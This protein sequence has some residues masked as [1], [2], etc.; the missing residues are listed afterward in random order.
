MNRGPWE[1]YQQPAEPEP[2]AQGP[3]SQYTEPEQGGSFADDLAY[4]VGAGANRGIAKVLGA[5]VDLVTGALNLIPGVD[6]QDPAGGS[7]QLERGMAE[8]GFTPPP[9]EDLPHPFVGRVAEEVG[10]AAVPFGVVGA[11]ARTAATGGHFGAPLLEAFRRTPRLNAAAESAAA[12]GAGTGAAI[13]QEVAPGNDMAELAGQLIG[14]FASP[15]A[16]ATD[17]TRKIGES[18][19]LVRSVDLM[20]PGGAR[21][22]AVRQLQEKVG[23]PEAAARI[24][25]QPVEGV[26][27][28]RLSPAQETGD[29][30]LLELERGLRRDYRDVDLPLQSA[31]QATQQAIRDEFADLTGGEARGQAREFLDE[32]LQGIQAQMQARTQQALTRAQERAEA[33][34]P[35]TSRAQLSRITRE[36]IED[37]LFDMR[38]AERE[39][40]TV[41]P[42]NVQADLTPLKARYRELLASLPQAQKDDMP[43]IAG[44][45]L[46]KGEGALGDV[47]AIKQVQGLRSKLLEVARNARAGDTPN[48]NQ[49][50][51]ADE[52]QEAALDVMSR[53]DAGPAVQEALAWSRDLN[54]RFRQGAVG[55]VLGQERRGGSAVPAEQT[56][57]RMVRQGVEGGVNYDALVR[58]VDTPE[59]RGAV[60]DYMR[61]LFVH[62]ATDPKGR[63]NPAAAH[64]F[65]RQH[66]EVLERM[67]EIRRQLVQAKSAQELAT[68]TENQTFARQ[69]GLM[70]K[71]KSRAALYLDA[72][73]GREM[74]AVLNSRNPVADMRQLVRQVRHDKTGEALKGLRAQFLDEALDAATRSGQLSSRDLDAFLLRHQK[75]L[76]DPIGLFSPSELRR[77]RTIQNTL[78]KG[79]NTGSA[80]QLPEL[81]DEGVNSHLDYVLRV[82][83]A[84]VG[85]QVGIGSAS[86]VA[87]HRGSALARAIGNVNPL[88]RVR[89]IL[90]E[91]VLDREVMADLLR[92]A[93]TRKRP[94]AVSARMNAWLA[95]LLPPPED[96]VADE[97]DR[98]PPWITPTQDSTAREQAAAALKTDGMPYP[99]RKS[100][101][102]AAKSRRLQGYRAVRV[103]GG[104]G[105]APPGG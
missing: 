53:S 2:A 13:A 8:L 98:L 87:A 45:L 63:V 65:L 37:A 26:P 41:V 62:S 24:L 70:D 57:D 7:R 18:G 97:G 35:G 40:W 61:T 39:L 100:A 11:I 83:G 91:A 52:I 34:P 50:R 64:R 90:S 32:R 71:R 99:T 44:R 93:G 85:S 86:L 105:L 42:E 25:E 6:I 82:I 30:Y 48:F 80:R 77:L 68:H 58:A 79:G 4:S 59:A 89:N 51:L 67:P 81:L 15:V 55:R 74:R 54:T 95:N 47:D 28:A 73:V 1:R 10:A 33:L 92:R 23:D 21:R 31:G 84:N 5:P 102:L 78:R 60:A 96:E 69:R 19:S 9:G 101:E 103:N 104:W 88:K 14:G 43:G 75:L 12:V 94:N 72:P 56:L 22:S 29:P 20:L 16:L 38:A 49:A 17:A 66:A 36:E 27:G 3:W 46:G 76:G